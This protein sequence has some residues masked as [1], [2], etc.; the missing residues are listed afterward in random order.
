LG[1]AFQIKDDELGIY[2]D[3][4]IMGKPVGSDIR[5][6]KKTL[7]RHALFRS[8]DEAVRPELELIYGS[9]KLTEEDMTIIREYLKK[10]NVLSLVRKVREDKSMAARDILEDIDIPQKYKL[11]FADLV[12]FSNDRDK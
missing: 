12:D 10:H 5:E 1:I 6:N 9:K 7:F 4:K 3:E 2:G 11:V 8:V